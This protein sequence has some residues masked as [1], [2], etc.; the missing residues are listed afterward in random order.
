[1]FVFIHGAYHCGAHF[2]EVAQILRARGHEAVAPD[3]PCTDPAMGAVEYAHVVNDALKGRE[4]AILVAHSMGGL[5]APVV[6]AAHSVRMIV[7][8]AALLPQP[9]MNF[10]TYA[11]REPDLFDYVAQTRPHANDDGS[12]TMTPARATETYYHDAGWRQAREAIGLLRPQHWK[13]MQESTP[14]AS[15]PD[16]ESRA[17]V[18][19]KDRTI[20][21]VWQRRVARERLDV[22]PIEIDAGHCPMTSR[23]DALAAILAELG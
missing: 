23:P 6:A 7:Y 11:S 20:S 1:M 15:M 22:E 3:L 13:I 9:G 17:I 4:D 2:G 18:C 16:V 19:A 12:A 5:T 10:D 14:L 21:P 8:L